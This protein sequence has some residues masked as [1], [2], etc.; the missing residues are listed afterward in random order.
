ME[1]IE[2]A[3]PFILDYIIDNFNGISSELKYDEQKTNELL[4]KL[5][6]RKKKIKNGK[7]T[8]TYKQTGTQGTGR[9]YAKQQYSLQSFPK[10]I[11]N[12]LAMSD[13]LDVDMSN[14]M[15]NVI[16]GECK[17]NNLPHGTLNE[18]VENRDESLNKIMELYKLKKRDDAKTKLLAITNN[19][20][21]KSNDSFIISLQEELNGYINH[22]YV[23]DAE[24]I[25]NVKRDMK[26]INCS[27]NEK[28]KVLV[29]KYQELE[30]KILLTAYTYLSAKKFNIGTLIHDGFLVEK[31]AHFDEDTLKL[32]NSQIK[33]KHNL[34]IEFTIKPFK[35][36]I[37]IPQ[38]VL[39]MN[40]ETN[41]DRKI[42]V[43]G[44]LKTKFEEM[45]FRINTPSIYIKISDGNEEHLK[46]HSLKEHFIDWEPAGID[47]FAIHC[48]K[49]K[50]FIENY[51]L[52]PTKKRYKKIGFYPYS[53]PEYNKC[54][55]NVFNSFTGFRIQEIIDKTI[56]PGE[57]MKQKVQDNLK[58]YLDHI[59]LLVDDCSDLVETNY[60][61]L[62]Q[63]FAHTVLRPDK[64]NGIVI[65]IKGIEGIGKQGFLSQV[66]G[67]K[68]MG[69][70]Y[71]MET[72]DP[73]NDI[74]GSFNSQIENKILINFDESK[75]EDMKEFHDRL[76]NFVTNPKRNIN[77]K[78]IAQYEVEQNYNFICTTNNELPFKISEHN[79]RI[80]IFESTRLGNK[81]PPPEYFRKLA[82]ALDDPLTILALFVHLQRIYDPE[83]NFIEIPRTD[84]YVRSEEADANPIYEWFNWIVNVDDDE[85]ESRNIKI[86]KRGK[87]KGKYGITMNNFLTAYNS[88]LFENSLNKVSMSLFKNELSQFKGT[89]EICRS[90]KGNTVY[91]WHHELCKY[92]VKNDKFIAFE[93]SYLDSDDESDAD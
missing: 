46:V 42:R 18:I 28:G 6:Q 65:T 41:R 53:L 52:D 40:F 62:L 56:N 23:N 19:E 5:N 50:T 14:A 61:Y 1:L 10:E 55:E 30:Q 44:E 45:M 78:N 33:E 93:L 71:Y 88:F 38:S 11:R 49:P 8:I 70:K 72:A 89:F 57:I 21:F 48:D 68:L 60:N 7:I 16:L 80:A 66:I 81:R 82:T 83:F 15:F 54:P 43:Y 59:K 47:K 73:K 77:K 87:H 12:T 69:S 86:T 29:N 13:Y 79:R 35:K 92:L 85:R 51:I 26:K 2:K 74:F 84:I 9:F 90:E 91:F 76:K 34:N 39:S 36:F 37:N 27:Y 20:E 25:K 64:T 4:N 3:Q 63:W 24:L 22:I 75:G 67:N 31:N 32:L 17:K 58:L